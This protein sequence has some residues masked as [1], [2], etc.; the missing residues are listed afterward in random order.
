MDG[1]M[2]AF[3]LSLVHI[4]ERAGHI[5]PDV[6]IV[7]RMPD[8]SLHRETYADLY[9]RA[10]A[11][12][13]GL[14]AAGLRR[15][16]RVAT[17][18][19]NHFAHLESYFGV[20]CAGGILHTLNLRLDPR[21]IAYIANHAGDRFLIVDDILVPLLEQILDETPFERIFVVPLSGAPIPGRFESYEDLLA[22]ADCSA[23]AYPAIGEEEAAG[24][25]YTSGTTGRP[26]GV[27]YSHRALSL[28]SLAIGL[29]DIFGFSMHDT[30]GPVVPMFHVNAWGIPFAATLNGCKQVFAGPHLDGESVLDL[31]SREQVT[32]SAGVPTIWFNVQETYF[33]DPRRWSLSPKL[34]VHVGGAPCP[35]SLLKAFDRMGVH[36]IH[37]WGMT[38][39][40]PVGTVCTVKP[41]ADLTDAAQRL[42]L[43]ARAGLPVPF[44]EARVANEDGI[45]PWDD[46]T[47]GELQVRGPW[48]AASY[49]NQPDAGDR[50]TDD[51]WFRT[52]DVSTI[53]AA[54]Y[55][56]ICDRTKDLV[57]SGGEWI[58]SVDL[59]NAI[60]GHPAVKEAAVIAVAHP[61]WQERPLACVVLNEDQDVSA[62]ALKAYLAPKFVKWWLPDGYVFVDEIP[63]TSTGKFKKSALRDKFKDW[64]WE[65]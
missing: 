39:T 33:T 8:R 1:T 65:R 16:D 34:R 62:E 7:S 20:P 35:Q 15:G 40:T 29:P 43:R 27:A 36:L 5:F 38:E 57:K 50:W 42:A 18:C 3:P 55:V 12:A 26:K 52:G 13:A 24:L 2:M 41:G 45:A 23:F 46:K 21:D 37:A 54:G 28:H 61:K 11:L 14:R 30:V 60:M 59:E 58:S 47:M 44:V 9:R 31:F 19:W 56:K 10:R 17:L 63:R 6:E 25:C 53:N 32:V 4:L 64:S 22:G 49:F 48:I 51:G